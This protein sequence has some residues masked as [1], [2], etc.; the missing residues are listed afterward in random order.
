MY[1]ELIGRPVLV[2]LYSLGFNQCRWGYT[3]QEMLEGVLQRAI[4]TQFPMEVLW[5]D[6]DY[7][8]RHL[9][10]SIN[11]VRYPNLTDF[12]LNTLQPKAVH[13]VPILDVGIGARPDNNP[14]YE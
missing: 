3:S 8:D 5:S 2:P 13:F 14:V 4:D 7:M 6:I 10:F 9:D 12:V 11:T 1:H